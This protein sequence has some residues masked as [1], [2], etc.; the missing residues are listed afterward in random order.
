M[1]KLP[2]LLIAALLCAFSTS[3]YASQ[4]NTLFVAL[5]EEPV[6][7]FDSV[8]G[9]GKYGNPLIQSTLLKYNKNFELQGDLAISWQLSEDKL[10]W[11]IKIRS[12]IL[13][14]DL[15]SLTAE[16]VAFTFLQ[17]KRTLSAHDL[18]NLKDVVVLSPTHLRFDL[19]QPD[20]TFIDHFV[21]IGIVPKHAYSKNYAQYPIGSGPYQF[22]Q[23]KK[24]QSVT[25][26]VNPNYYAEKPAFNE[27]VIVFGS[28][29]SRFALFKT[30]QLHLTT[31]PQ[32]FVSSLP[33]ESKLWSINSVDNRGI[34]WP[35]LSTKEGNK[36]S[37]ISS[38]IAIRQ[39]V[40]LAIDRSVII[41]Q[42]LNGYAHPAYS[43][44]D[45]LPWGPMTP[46]EHHY[47]V[48]RAQQTLTS[49]GWIDSNNDGI[50]ERNSINAE[51]TLYYKAGDSVREELAI[52]ISQMLK[53]IGIKLDIV[54]ADW[55]TIAKHMHNNPVLMGF[56]SH[57][58]NEIR[59]LFHSDYAG[60]D[61]YN[62]GLYQNEEVDHLIDQ[63]IHASSW[64][65][66]LPLWQESQKLIEKD[67]PWTWLVNLDHLYAT[68][69][70]LDLGS[71]L[72]EPH[73]HGW[74]LVSNI[75]EWRWVCQ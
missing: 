30:G 43:V 54:G 15:S 13:F 21:S 51:M 4:P 25:L 3:S 24:G 42:L 52:T 23:W 66:S 60:V 32:K 5:G 48:K 35:M 73:A 53:P 19:K 63:A 16:D 56:G 45:G 7:G 50:R 22:V 20:I 10:S 44:A 14:S 58:A 75:A 27:L 26:R 70:C 74:P 65:E 18:S 59:S 37:A 71:P 49:A 28:E 68:N 61:F 62:S 72:T 17:A 6:K 40:D 64:Q 12:D 2:V 67:L 41:Q 46:S 39:A 69:K 1:K 57:S 55:D 8:L 38:D 47:D 29:S 11:S 31:L 9:W 34:V 33:K 36:E